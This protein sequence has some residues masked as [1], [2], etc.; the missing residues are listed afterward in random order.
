MKRSCGAGHK[1]PVF[2][3]LKRNGR[4][5]VEVIKN[6]S[7]AQLIPIVKGKVIEGDLAL[8]NENLTTT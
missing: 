3:M 8:M 1:I 2:G 4:V 5:Y 6:W 7:R